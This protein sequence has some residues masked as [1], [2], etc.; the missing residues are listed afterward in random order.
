M[1]K[2][3]DLILHPWHDDGKQ[4]QEMNTK[5]SLQGEKSS[6]CCLKTFFYKQLFI[7]ASSCLGDFTTESTKWNSY[8]ALVTW[9]KSTNRRATAGE[10]SKRCNGTYESGRIDDCAKMQRHAPS[11]KW[12]TPLKLPFKHSIFFCHHLH[13]LFVS[14]T[15]QLHRAGGDKTKASVF[16]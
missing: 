10:E 7:S 13:N 1:S 11:S 14:V 9:R 16:F 4:P 8:R 12:K 15:Q 6:H 5:D 3:L 2:R